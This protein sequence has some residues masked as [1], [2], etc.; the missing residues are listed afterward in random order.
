MAESV[1]GP[2]FRFLEAC[3]IGTHMFDPWS[4]QSNELE[5]H[6]C[7][8][9]ITHSTLL[10]YDNDWL[11]QGQETVIGCDFRTCCWC[12]GLSVG[13]P[14]K[15]TRHQCALLEVGTHHDMTLDVART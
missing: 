9:L 2:F 12:P 1:E 8:F 14:Y 5:I 13:Q 4:S 11:A 3:W 10:S 15:G 6:Y 7:H